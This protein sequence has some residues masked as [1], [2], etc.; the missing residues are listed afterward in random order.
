ML[1]LD[2]QH[3]RRAKRLGEAVEQAVEPGERTSLGRR[4][5]FEH[6]P[7]HGRSQCEG[8]KTGNRHRYDDGN[9]ELLVE[10]PVVPGKNAAGINTDAITST[11]AMSGVPISSMALIVASLGEM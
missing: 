10:L 8:H 3:H 2:H 7:A 6:E 5:M 9:G 1:S 11:T 4:G